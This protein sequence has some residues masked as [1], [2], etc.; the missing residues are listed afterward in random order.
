VIVLAE[1]V[2]AVRASEEAVLVAAELLE[3]ADERERMAYP[4]AAD[5]TTAATTTAEA[6]LPMALRLLATK[7]PLE[8]R[9]VTFH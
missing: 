9:K 4:T 3:L 7:C 5:S 8:A 1:A 2:D 6:A